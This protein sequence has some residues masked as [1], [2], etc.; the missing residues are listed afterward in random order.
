MIV[1]ILSNY[2]ENDCLDI[3]GL[4]LILYITSQSLFKSHCF[5]HLDHF[6]DHDA[7]IFGCCQFED[8]PFNTLFQKVRR[9]R[10]FAQNNSENS[11]PFGTYSFL[12]TD[13]CVEVFEYL[14]DKCAFYQ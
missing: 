2:F 5:F 7:H 3:D 13:N 14:I 11:E 10:Q 1:I 6:L 8:L 4:I 12:R 9:F